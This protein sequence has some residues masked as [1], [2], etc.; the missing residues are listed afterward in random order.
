MKTKTFF[1]QANNH[2][3]Q[4]ITCSFIDQLIK[5]IYVSVIFFYR[6]SIH[7]DLLIDSLKQV[8]NDFPIFAGVLIN[9]NHHLCI[10]CNNKGILFS[11]SNDDS[12][13]E[14][15]I[16]ELP[17]IKATRLVDIINPKKA[18][19]TQSPI[20]TI[21]L[22][23]FTC[24]GMTLGVCWHHSIGDMHSFMCFMRAWSKTARKEAYV[25][26][27]IVKDRDKYIE[28]NLQKI[29]TLFLGLGI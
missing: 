18:I 19:F 7:F 4:M 16:K 15:V 13:L 9:I 29:K 25:L 17:T 23:Y 26:P 14:Q 5:N 12:T 21:Q 28:E 1:V 8:L 2:T 11:I 22:T 20:M 10:D 3:Q 27:L 24:G 6:K